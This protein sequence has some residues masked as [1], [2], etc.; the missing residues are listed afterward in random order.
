MKLTLKKLLLTA[1]VVTSILTAAVGG[2][3]LYNMNQINDASRAIYDRE[4]MG[5]SYIKDAG[6]H[7]AA[8]ARDWRT[9]LIAKDEEARKKA[10]AGLEGR[11]TKLEEV[12]E[13]ADPL[14]ISP[15]GRELI[16]QVREKHKNWLSATRALA[17][18]AEKEPYL[19]LPAE[20]MA[21]WK[22]QGQHAKETDELFDQLTAN[23]EENAL[24]TVGFIGSLYE[25]SKWTLT[26]FVLFAFAAGISLGFLITR[27]VMRQ[28]GGE[29][30][31]A[32]DLVK[33][34]ADGD[35]TVDIQLVKGD[36]TSL[37]YD[38]KKMTER[39]A[40]V[41]TEVRASCDSL[42]TASEQV[43]ATSGNLSNATSEQAA[44]V[45]ETTASIEQISSSITQNSDN[46]RVTSDISTKAARD[47]EEGGKAVAS[48]VEAMRSIAD[49]VMIIDDIAY[50]T[51]LL[52]LNAAIE[53]A[54]AGEHGKG[55]AVVATEVRKLAERSQEAAQE[56]GKLAESSVNVAEKAGTLLNKIV[57]DIKRTSDLV[58]EIT[59]ASDEQKSAGQQISLSMTQLSQ[60]TQQ[61]A[62]A[63]EELAATAEEM[64]DHAAQLQ[65]L[66]AFFKTSSQQMNRMSK[67]GHG[68][69][70]HVGSSVR[71]NTSNAAAKT[72]DEFGEF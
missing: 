52:A 4:L 15:E 70:K 30:S 56:I 16:K 23:K 66:V 5:L 7:R 34:I 44:S 27:N 62:S 24:K 43:S 55:F 63:S 48:T 22:A 36:T 65:N 25:S 46:S 21:T 38:M 67:P 69:T 71:A 61:N 53:A 37:L 57:P 26:V 12:I 29:P 6:I 40:G 10:R 47:A 35:M 19:A 45:E 60:I 31:Y 2:L 14:F 39:L 9:I 18:A 28:I 8:A 51:N 59:A 68:K 42:A 33:R 3:G 64:N 11:F 41:V 17:D 20:F 50:Q 72:D 32:G 58:Q 13:K 1:F 54:R 49:K